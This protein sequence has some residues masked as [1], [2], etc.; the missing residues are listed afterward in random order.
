MPPGFLHRF[1]SPTG[2]EVEY[3]CTALWDPAQEIAV[4]WDDPQIGIAWPIG[5]P[6]LSEKDAAAPLLAEIIDRL[7]EYRG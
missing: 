5:A 2:G 6:Q 1:A 3:K 4:R 7:P